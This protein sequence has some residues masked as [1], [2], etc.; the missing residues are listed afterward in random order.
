LQVESNQKNEL[1]KNSPSK[2]QHKAN[3]ARPSSSN[4]AKSSSVAVMEKFDNNKANGNIIHITVNNFI[5]NNNIT[6]P[7]VQ[8]NSNVTKIDL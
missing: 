2:E 7:N 6:S 3:S 1:I 8:S 5:T 4:M